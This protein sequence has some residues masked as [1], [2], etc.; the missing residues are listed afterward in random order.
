[1]AVSARQVAVATEIQLDGTN[2]VGDQPLRK[3]TYCRFIEFV[4]NP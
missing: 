2:T 3:M 1:M 4:H